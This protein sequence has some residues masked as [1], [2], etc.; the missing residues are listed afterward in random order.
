MSKVAIFEARKVITM[1][2]S[3]PEGTH[4][5]VRQGRILG[6]GSLDD[7][8][9]WGDYELDTTFSDKVL[10]PGFVEAHGHITEGAFWEFPY[11]GYFDRIGADGTLW[12]GCTGL[13]Y[14]VQVLNK[15]DARMSSPEEML[16]AWGI[17]LLYFPGERI[18]KAHLDAVSATRPIFVMHAGGHLATVNSAMLRK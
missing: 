8:A 17:D 18:T 1:N 16:I 4:I 13:E 5:A 9:G 11:V 14:V 12:K 3:N 2:P 6:V 10:V 7:V 15:V